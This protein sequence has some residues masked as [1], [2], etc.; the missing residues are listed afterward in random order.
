M[1]NIT[2]R[3]LD[4]FWRKVRTPQIDP[5]QGQNEQLA[6]ELVQSFF[7]VSIIFE[8]VAKEQGAELMQGILD[9]SQGN[10][11]ARIEERMRR[12]EESRFLFKLQKPGSNV[13]IVALPTAP[14]DD[15]FVVREE[16][17]SPNLKSAKTIVPPWRKSFYRWEDTDRLATQ[18]ASA[19]GPN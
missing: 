1:E 17:K 18:I 9:Y 6:R 19:M 15:I 16:R 8:R 5:Q 2:R 3:G 14:R 7:S 13:S 4:I 12:P 10:L 11:A